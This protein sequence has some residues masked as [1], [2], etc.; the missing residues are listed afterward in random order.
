MIYSV[1]FLWNSML[2]WWYG[3]LTIYC[4]M[5]CLIWLM[6]KHRGFIKQNYYRLTKPCF[7]RHAL[8]LCVILMVFYYCTNGCKWSKVQRPGRDVSAGWRLLIRTSIL[9]RLGYKN[10]ARH[11]TCSRL[12]DFLFPDSE[13]SIERTICFLFTHSVSMNGGV[14]RFCF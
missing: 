8:I 4:W 10:L 14:I 9:I 13:L 11:W 2:R 6:I 3:I 5:N 1:R 7:I 12:R